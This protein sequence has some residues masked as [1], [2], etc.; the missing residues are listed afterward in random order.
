M[1]PLGPTP[2]RRLNEAGGVVCLFSSVFLTLS[3]ASYHPS[4]PSL[5][6]ATSAV[7]PGNLTGTTGAYV[8]DFLLQTF[9]LSSLLLPF[10][11]LVVGWKWIWSKPIDRQ[12]ARIIG[13]ILLTA[14]CAATLS[15]TTDGYILETLLP[16]GVIGL[17]TS[18]TLISVLNLTGTIL[19]LAP[20]AAAFALP[21]FR[22]RPVPSAGS[23]ELLEGCSLRNRRL[24]ARHQV[25]PSIR[26][27]TPR[28]GRRDR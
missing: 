6:T 26:I 2:Y 4:D 28:H 7:E 1:K 22:V 11:L 21:D 10:F 24:G 20:F 9:G 18:G 8:A 15:L 14:S 16:G 27:P 5:N 3:L 17:L 25:S 13:A 23:P 19:V 12:P